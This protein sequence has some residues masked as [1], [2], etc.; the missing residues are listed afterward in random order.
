MYNTLNYNW[1]DIT[2]ILLYNIYIYYRAMKSKIYREKNSKRILEEIE[3]VLRTKDYISSDLL[4]DVFVE[5]LP[6]LRKAY[7]IEKYR[8][9]LR[10]LLAADILERYRVGRRY[11]YVPKRVSLI[12]KTA[13]YF[14]KNSFLSHF[15][16]LYL[17][18]LTIQSPKK[19]YVSYEV[20]PHSYTSPEEVL[21][22]ELLT[23]D[24]IDRAFSKP[25]KEPKNFLELDNY[26]VHFIA[27][28]KT[29]RKGIIRREIQGEFISLTILERT[30]IEAVIRPEY[31]G[32]I[33]EVVQAFKMAREYPLSTQR[34]MDIYNALGLVYPYYQAIG[35]LLEKTHNINDKLINTLY[36]I[37][38]YF[39][40]YLVHGIPK[41]DLLFDRKWKIYYPKFLELR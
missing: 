3:T 17:H 37:P 2:F 5:Y 35:F 9:F 39:N 30:L 4:K 27:R 14:N 32:G 23:Q 40:F 8:Q 26:K 15:T 1:F 21:R 28:R 18:Q 10:L 36:K 20:L 12:Y 31:C 6:S 16:A 11:V 13:L 41:K 25:V 24:S 7:G 33:D 38:R 19:I 22:D 29:F 34:F